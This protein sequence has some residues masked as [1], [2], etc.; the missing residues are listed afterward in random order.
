[1]EVIVCAIA[2]GYYKNVAVVNSTE[3]RTGSHND[4]WVVIEPA[5]NLTLIKKSNLTGNAKV[6]DLV[7]FTIVITNN[8]PSVAN[9]VN[10]TDF[11][12][13]GLD[14]VSS[15]SNITGVNGKYSFMDNIVV[16]NMGSLAKG[17]KALVWVVVNVT[18]NGTFTNV[19]AVNS[20]ENTT[21]NSNKTNITVDSAVELTITKT[22][23][24]TEVNV[25]D[26]VE[27]TIVVTNRGP[28]NAT[29]VVVRD[30]L[31]EL[32]EFKSGDASVGEY[33]E[34]TGIWSIPKLVNGANATLTIV[35]KVISNG[36]ISN[37]AIVNCSEN[38]TNKNDS[39]E[40]IPA[41]PIVDLKINK[42]VD[43]TETQVGE[44]ITYTIVVINNGPSDAT[45]VNVAENIKGNVEIIAANS[46]KGK[47]NNSTG[48]WAIGG[49]ANGE[50]VN[51]TITVKLIEIGIVENRVSVKS[52]E[53]DTNSSNNNYTSDNVTVNPANSTVKGE[54]VVV[55]YG[56]PIT[57][58]VESE[59][60]TFI[61]Y[62]II[63]SNG[64]IVGEGILDVGENIADLTLAGGEYTVN[65]TT[66]TDRNHYPANNQSKI[67]V[68]PIAPALDIETEN[69]TYGDNETITIILSENV[70]GKINVTVGNETF[71]DLEIE[72]GTVNITISNLSA[73][74]YTV[75][76]I[77]PGNENYTSINGKSE[78]IVKKS[79]T[80][81]DLN[82][83]DIYYGDN[84]I[85]TVILPD[86]VGGTVNITIGNHTYDNLPI[87]KGIVTLPV[88]DLG[89]GNC[90]VVV[91]YGGDDTTIMET[92][93]PQHS[94]Y[95]L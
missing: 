25:T 43:A 40:N 2:N 29:S 86:D 9:N 84:E 78:F 22:V 6:N 18:N 15:G 44:E 39:S 92:Q 83:Y 74:N 16:W 70:T 64:N 11:L 33:N 5:V 72:K 34:T 88:Y 14:Y 20:S 57:V 1:M 58:L 38:S 75:N 8:G 77:Y 93:P 36:I 24:A 46:S 30:K 3:N 66:I 60:A 23:N 28:S 26:L 50:K 56:N 4:T 10:I 45:G 85:I 54:D 53:N 31:S 41:H 7:K 73:G 90:T 87:N 94:K 55:N 35:A 12:P 59:N 67:T 21:G 52:N 62:K 80:P 68:N 69:I 27:F 37:V 42:T 17:A 91:T 65:M 95:C 79:D 61:E 48:L 19:A 49:L 13:Q 51:L 47:Y 71:T 76:V 32:L 89:G 82:I 81:I 63:D